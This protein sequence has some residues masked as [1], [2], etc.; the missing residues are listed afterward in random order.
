MTRTRIAAA[1]FLLSFPAC[2]QSTKL[3][4]GAAQLEEVIDETAA[5][6]L[7]EETETSIE[8]TGPGFCSN[9]DEGDADYGLR[10]PVEGIDTARLFDETGEHWRRRGFTVTEARNEQIP[11]LFAT[12]RG[13]S[14]SIQVHPRDGFGVIGGSTPCL[15]G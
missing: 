8:R 12:D 15:E 4:E 7:P 11:A 2:E 1:L 9:D 6:V 3:D 13:F 10:F 5:T 14:Y